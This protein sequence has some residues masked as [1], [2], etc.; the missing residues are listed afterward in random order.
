MLMQ[1]M[2]FGFK[3]VIFLFV[4]Y[5]PQLFFVTFFI[6]LIEYFLVFHFFF[7]ISC[8]S[9]LYI[10]V[11]DLICTVHISLPSNYIILFLILYIKPS[12]QYIPFFLSFPLYFCGHIFTFKC[13][14][15][16]NI[17]SLNHQLYF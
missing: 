13:H 17:S 1:L 10:F 2:M 11:I 6:F 14:K 3:S 8:I 4:F 15:S 9:L 12:Q 5:F 16:H 7:T